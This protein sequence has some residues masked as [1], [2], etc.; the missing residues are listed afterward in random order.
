MAKNKQYILSIDQ[1]TTSSR[2]VLFDENYEIISIG[3]NEF[4][5]FFPDSGWVEHDPEEIWTSTLESCR[6]AIKQSKIDPNQIRAIGITNQRETTVVWDKETGIPI[7]NAIVWQDR[8]TSDYCQSLRSLG[9]ESLVNQKTG[10][11]LDPYFCATKIAWILDNVDGAREKA[12]KGG[13]LFGTIDCFLMW[14]LSNQKIHS[15]DATNACRTLLYNIHEGCWDKD[16]LDLFNVPAS[17]LPEVY[18]NATDFGVAD[19]SIFGSEIAI[20]ASIGD[21][22]SALVGQACFHPGMVKST[23]GTGCF[24]L[25]NTGYEPVKSNNKLLTTLAFQVNGKTCYALEG[26]IFIAGA[27]VQWLRDGLKFIESAEQSETLAM[28]ADDSQDVYLVPAFVGLGAPHWDPDCRGALFGMT[29]NTG[30]AEITK[31]TLESVCYQTSD[32]LSAISKDLG[33]SKLSAIRVDG[34][35]AASNWTMQMLSDLVELPVDRPKNLETTAL[36]AAYL[37]GMQVGF[38]PPMDEFS[39]SWQ[40][41]SQFN[42]KMKAELRARKLAGWKDAVRRTLS[43]N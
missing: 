10:L 3:Q 40:S 21:Q 17:M 12:N 38:Y 31:A 39:E 22:P 6:S 16:L 32:L 15:T 23:Y 4:T 43:N 14:R 34:G 24:V 42:S 35:M 41:E 9:H 28:K 11:L 13:L 37:A 1:G 8:R 2:G 7:Y 18:D 36:G 27:A 5:Q 20:A 29:R 33:E 30:P 19:E 26:S 25:I